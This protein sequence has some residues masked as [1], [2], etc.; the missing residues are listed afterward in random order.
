VFGEVRAGGEGGLEGLSIVSNRSV[1]AEDLV[2]IATK[3]GE[4]HG[5]SNS[6][7]GDRSWPKVVKGEA[8]LNAAIDDDQQRESGDQSAFIESL[9]E[10]LSVDEL[11]KR[12]QGEDWDVYVRQM[13]NS[14]MIPPVGGVSA[15]SK[16]ADTMASGKTGTDTPD[17][18]N[19]EVHEFGYGTQKQTIIL[20]DR[21]GKVK[22]V[23]RTLYDEDG[24]KM[25]VK[26]G[27]KEFEFEIE[28]WQT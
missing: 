17:H 22:F 5:L 24:N 7:F 18:G 14:I 20:V 16:P 4:T 3:S 21:E 1:K 13:R 9:F 23:E 19:V 25:E 12:K 2:T 10:I 11:P 8:M 6:Y 28:G 26:D 27:Q 15:E